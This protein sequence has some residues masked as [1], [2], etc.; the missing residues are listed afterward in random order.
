[1][2]PVGQLQEGHDEVQVLLALLRPVFDLLGDGRQLALRP[3]GDHH[4]HRVFGVTAGA[5]AAGAG[6]ST[7]S[8]AP[9]MLFGR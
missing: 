1:M 3:L 8:T 9:T 2:A 5:A 6:A 7:C 4:A